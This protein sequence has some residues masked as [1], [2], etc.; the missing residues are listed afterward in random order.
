MDQS[1]YVDV[2]LE[3]RN[4]LCDSRYI[5]YVLDSSKRR[6]VAWSSLF[7]VKVLVKAEFDVEQQLVSA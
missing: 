7:A 6:F 2:K 3:S 5:L 1:R 4:M